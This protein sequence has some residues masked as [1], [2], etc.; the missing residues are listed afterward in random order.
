MIGGQ[1][2]TLRSINSEKYGYKNKSTF[3][4]DEF[5]PGINNHGKK[6]QIQIHVV[7]KDRP[8]KRTHQSL[9]VHGHDYLMP[10]I[11]RERFLG[12]SFKY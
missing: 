9:R 12:Q 8:S 1:R 5:K 2:L 10:R 7:K 11:C 6:L 3:I 4:C